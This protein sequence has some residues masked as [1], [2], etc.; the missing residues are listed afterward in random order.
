MKEEKE[1]DESR[2]SCSSLSDYIA[3]DIKCLCSYEVFFLPERPSCSLRCHKSRSEKCSAFMA[4]IESDTHFI[5]S[6][7]LVTEMSLGSSKQKHLVPFKSVY[8]FMS[9]Q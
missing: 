9:N 6:P 3:K 4:L 7:C 2:L 5:Y 8:V 1:I